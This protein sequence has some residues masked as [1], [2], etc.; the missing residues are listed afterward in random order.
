[1]VKPPE[2]AGYNRTATTRR[3]PG[4]AADRVQRPHIH[5][6]AQVGVGVTLGAG[7]QIEKDAVVEEGCRLGA[8]AVVREGAVLE[9]EARLIG[10][11]A[12]E[13]NALVR[14]GEIVDKN[15]PAPN[16]I[17]PTAHIDPTADIDR[18]AR[19]GPGSSVAEGA[20]IGPGADVGLTGGGSKTLGAAIGRRTELGKDSVV[21][22][23]AVIGDDC[24]VKRGA[25]VAQNSHVKNKCE[26]AEHAR[27]NA[28]CVLREGTKV[29]RH[30]DVGWGS[31]TGERVVIGSGAELAP[32][33]VAGGGAWIGADAVIKP[34]RIAP[35]GQMA[36]AQISVMI[37]EGARIGNE[38]EVEPKPSKTDLEN[39]EDLTPGGVQVARIEAVGA[40]ATMEPGSRVGGENRLEAGDRLTETGEVYYAQAKSA[41]GRAET[42]SPEPEISGPE[43]ARPGADGSAYDKP[44][45]AQRSN[46]PETGRGGGPEQA[47]ADRDAGKR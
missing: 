36:N 19:V 13:K 30:A 6:G 29:G 2:S 10:G 44:Q 20:K 5:A 3:G 1:M 21:M 9:K 38:A 16:R 8:G 26:I 22:R 4:E 40:G 25:L 42:I 33:T 46:R 28:D 11:A 43:T 23:G 35:G 47:P 18:R 17:S 31:E 24:S 41:Q 12:A 39:T 45:A 37:G 34:N 7:V 15:H 27:V 14:S 32:L